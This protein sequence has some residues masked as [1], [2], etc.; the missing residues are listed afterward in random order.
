MCRIPWPMN[1]VLN[2][3]YMSIIY[4]IRCDYGLHDVVLQFE[5][6]IIDLL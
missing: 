4:H 3:I 2:P 5:K 1:I 6:L